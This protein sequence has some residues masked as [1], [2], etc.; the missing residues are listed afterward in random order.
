MKHQKRI[1]SIVILIT[2]GALLLGFTYYKTQ[3]SQ[4][5]PKTP[6]LLTENA[7]NLQ[8]TE[9]LLAT[10]FP[11]KEKTWIQ[12]LKATALLDKLPKDEKDPVQFLI[13]LNDVLQTNWLRAPGTERYQLSDDALPVK[14]RD[15]IRKALEQLGLYREV[16]PTKQNGQFTT[17]D[18][19]FLMGALQS[20]VEKRFDYLLSLWEKG[21]RFKRLYILSGERKLAGKE[22][23]P[24]TEYFEKNHQEANEENMVKHIV[25]HKKMPFS[26][27]EA[28][29]NGTLEMIYVTS[30]AKPNAHRSKAFDNFIGW[31]NLYGAQGEMTRQDKTILII[32]NQPF[33]AY[34]G[35]VAS[36]A[37]S[38]EF[39]EPVETLGNFDN[40]YKIGNNYF[41]EVVGPGD[42]P[43]T[44]T[45]GLDSLARWVYIS[46]L[47][48][49]QMI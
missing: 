49:N 5:I 25:T 12:L 44:L 16:P 26:M 37:M 18:C 13:A 8:A 48:L 9:H 38:D 35:A 19:V 33:V 45:V 39:H 27:Q 28:L 4:Q 3:S 43:R 20:R 41:I 31:M 6:P 14:Q 34:I 2:L 21:V 40:Q 22:I 30:S 24:M 7:E 32:S 17:Y 29:N 23:E 1:R 10:F 36:R 42:T 11:G 15:N 47:R 46:L